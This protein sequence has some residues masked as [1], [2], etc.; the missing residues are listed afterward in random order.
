M[1]PICTEVKRKTSF[2]NMELITSIDALP[3]TLFKEMD[4]ALSFWGC[5]EL[6]S[7]CQTSGALIVQPQFA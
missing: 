3:L 7:A 5:L 4:R 1:F 6:G 2:E